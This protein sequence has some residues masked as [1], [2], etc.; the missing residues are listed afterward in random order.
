MNL[1]QMM[2]AMPSGILNLLVKRHW[3]FAVPLKH[4]GIIGHRQRVEHRRPS[5]VRAFKHGKR[6]RNGQAVVGRLDPV[7][8]FEANNQ[9]RRFGDYRFDAAID[10]HVNIAK[11]VN[12]LA[13]R[14][15]AVAVRRIQLC[16]G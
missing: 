5:R 11:M 10:M 2:A 3:T 16:V 4:P 13:N 8:L 12:D 1:C 6:R 14:P 9:R 7:V 15:A